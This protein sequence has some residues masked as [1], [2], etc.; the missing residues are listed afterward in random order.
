MLLLCLENWASC[1]ANIFLLVLHTAALKDTFQVQ[2]CEKGSLLRAAEEQ[3]YIHFVDFLDEC[4]GIIIII[5]I[6]IIP[7]QFF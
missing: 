7:A 2:Y 3:T 5:F 4:A 1:P 6:I